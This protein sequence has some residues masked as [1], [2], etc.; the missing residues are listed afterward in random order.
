MQGKLFISNEMC[1]ILADKIGWLKYLIDIL[2]VYDVSDEQKT[3]LFL[4]D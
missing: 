1:C 3:K 2:N 4:F